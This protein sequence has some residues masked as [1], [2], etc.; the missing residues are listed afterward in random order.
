MYF[1][2][3]R[4]GLAADLIM[5]LSVCPELEVDGEPRGA[6]AIATVTNA[7]SHSGLREAVKKQFGIVRTSSTAFILLKSTL[8]TPMPVRI[9]IHNANPADTIQVRFS[10]RGHSETYS[11]YPRQTLPR[12]RVT[13]GTWTTLSFKRR[14][15]KWSSQRFFFTSDGQ[16]W[17]AEASLSCEF[18]ND[19]ATISG[20]KSENLSLGLESWTV[21]GDISDESTKLHWCL[22]SPVQPPTL[23]K[24]APELSQPLNETRKELILDKARYERWE[25]GCSKACKPQGKP[26]LEGFF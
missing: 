17:G 3:F 5:R 7:D 13:S 26:L 12:V 4:R 22:N 1:I 15:Y 11:V 14:N 24:L 6:H 16:Y 20:L 21:V 25:L 23:G 18:A 19:V 8:N 2:A 9:R 10:F